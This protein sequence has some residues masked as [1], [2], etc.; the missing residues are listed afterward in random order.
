MDPIR[1]GTMRTRTSRISA[2]MSRARLEALEGAREA[3]EPSKVSRRRGATLDDVI[4]SRE[5]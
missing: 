5:S 1:G 3:A 4:F 2:P